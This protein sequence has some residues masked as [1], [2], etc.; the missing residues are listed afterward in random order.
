MVF[1]V[2]AGAFESL[3]AME[4]QHPGSHPEFFYSA[5][6]NNRDLPESCIRQS[7]EAFKNLP[8][9]GHHQNIWRELLHAQISF[10]EWRNE[11]HPNHD[12]M[13]ALWEAAC[14]YLDLHSTSPELE[15]DEQSCLL[16]WAISNHCCW[17]EK[18]RMT[19]EQAQAW[20]KLDSPTS[21][22]PYA[23]LPSLSEAWW[24]VFAGDVVNLSSWSSL[25]LHSGACEGAGDMLI[26]FLLGMKE[27]ARLFLEESTHPD[28]SS[29]SEPSTEEHDPKPYKAVSIQTPAVP[30]AVETAHKPVEP[31]KVK[32]PKP[33]SQTYQT[34]TG[35][36]TNRYSG[37]SSNRDR[38][39]PKAT[40]KA[41]T[42]DT[43]SQKLKKKEEKQAR[44]QLAAKQA[45]ED[46]QAAAA[47]AA[48]LRIEQQNKVQELKNTLLG[49]KEAVKELAALCREALTKPSIT[50]T[51]QGN[52]HK[53]EVDLQRLLS[54]IDQHVASLG[55]AKGPKA[56]QFIVA[57]DNIIAN[58]KRALEKTIGIVNSN[59]EVMKPYADAFLDLLTKL[60]DCDKAA[61]NAQNLCASDSENKKET[62]NRSK[63]KKP[64]VVSRSKEMIGKIGN[65]IQCLGS[66][67]AGSVSHV[68]SDIALFCDVV[69]KEVGVNEE[70][71]GRVC[72]DRLDSY[73]RWLEPVDQDPSVTDKTTGII[74]VPF[75]N[76][77]HFLEILKLIKGRDEVLKARDQIA[78]ISNGW[79]SWAASAKEEFDKL[80]KFLNSGAVQFS[81]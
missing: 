47:Q 9:D 20:E 25:M 17:Q 12:K 81:R 52:W 14:S 58:K 24:R 53:Q 4:V 57:M 33:R 3:K 48:Q 62:H 30:Q 64:E 27:K 63:G 32:V 72:Q 51:Q 68:L 1:S 74:S 49:Q 6:W 31:A 23:S 28:T 70:A 22:N 54:E 77:I 60:E 80:D 8:A 61:R 66:G 76:L 50:R 78:F 11:A 46:R 18:Q 71:L 13:L 15:A 21:H 59:I 69:T 39:D 35:H 65:L 26:K 40:N 43:A 7:L 36:K 75:G 38:L 37:V 16:W 19:L 5:I 41:A 42:N 79:R 44:A 29:P 10:N 34:S 73:S 55:T 56:E 2:T 45:E 67:D